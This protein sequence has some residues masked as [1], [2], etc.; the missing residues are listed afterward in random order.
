M[1]KALADDL[2]ARA[3][4]S[5]AVTAALTARHA[6]EQA[7]ERT[8]D[9]YDVW[10]RFFTKQV[11]AAWFLSCVFVRVLEDRGLVDQHRLAGPGA[12]DSQQ[13]FFELAPSLSTRDVN[14]PRW[15]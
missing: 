3:K 9:P 2:L 10:L 7:Q 4:A 8:A 12:L 6:G 13:L 15:A 11:A 5:P 14:L 1:L